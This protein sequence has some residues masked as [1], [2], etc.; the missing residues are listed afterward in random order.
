[1]KKADADF[2]LI[3]QDGK[4]VDEFMT[5]KVSS[6]YSQIKEEQIQI[7]KD[8]AEFQNRSRKF[9]PKS[10]QPFRR[11]VSESRATTT[12][13]FTDQKN[14]NTT[15]LNRIRAETL[16]QLSSDQKQQLV[17][18]LLSQ[19]PAQ[20]VDSIAVQQLVALPCHRLTAVMG[21]LPDEVSQ[22]KMSADFTPFSPLALRAIS[23]ITD[24]T[25]SDGERSCAGPVPPSQG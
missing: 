12:E 5:I 1:M 21:R 17:V 16:P 19:L 4:Q 14:G 15:N 18:T 9:V 22:D 11:G 13:L 6:P 23:Q 24:L 3:N 10:P 8:R 25:V 20:V 7:S 2:K